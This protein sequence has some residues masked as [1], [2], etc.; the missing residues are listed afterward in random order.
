MM[1][2]FMSRCSFGFFV[3][4]MLFMS[5]CSG[6]KNPNQNT[7]NSTD[8]F[9]DFGKYPDTAFA[10]IFIEQPVQDA[11]NILIEQQ[12][13]VTDSSG[14]I[15][16]YRNMDST[17]V[18]LKGEQVIDEVRVVMRSINKI[19]A[20]GVLIKKFNCGKAVQNT[21]RNYFLFTC[22]GK[23]GVFKTSVFIQ[24]DYIRISF[25]KTHQ[26]GINQGV[27]GQF[28]EDTNIVLVG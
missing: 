7:G 23:S 16:L 22:I 21:K 15:Q 1:T 26:Y 5:A 25:K 17:V 14:S 24:S 9:A 28:S 8:L 3:L 2:K 6:K 4:T 19:N 27:Q 20:S 18:L 11:K 10:G 13:I 12:F